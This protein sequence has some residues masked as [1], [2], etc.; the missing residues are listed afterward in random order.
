MGGFSNSIQTRYQTF[1]RPVQQSNPD[2]K[3][4]N[5]RHQ[6]KENLQTDTKRFKTV[7]PH[8]GDK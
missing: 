5:K 6:V 7:R 8:Y 3:V 1:Q 2:N 4:S